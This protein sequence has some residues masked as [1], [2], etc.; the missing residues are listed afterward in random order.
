MDSLAGIAL[1][2]GIRLTL[3]LKPKPKF[4]LCFISTPGLIL[5]LNLMLGCRAYIGGKEAWERGPGPG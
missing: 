3:T 5:T 4:E 2:M 1:W